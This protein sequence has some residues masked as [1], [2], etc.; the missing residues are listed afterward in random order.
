MKTAA[1][2]IIL[3]LIPA[4]SFSQDSGAVHLDKESI[5]IPKYDLHLGIGLHR[6][7]RIG[8]RYYFHSN[9]SLESSVGTGMPV[10][11]APGEYKFT[12]GVNYH[13]KIMMNWPLCLGFTG[14]SLAESIAQNPL[15]NVIVGFSIGRINREDRGLKIFFRIG[16]GINIYRYPTSP[17]EYYHNYHIDN[18][19]K[20]ELD[21]GIL[22][23]F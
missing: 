13:S 15:N 18:T 17:N 14:N 23:N 6:G 2:L 10:F 12:I 8:G 9:W 5:S 7:L 11:D 22:F 4:F 16:V 20:P 19:L 1:W 21:A 3:L